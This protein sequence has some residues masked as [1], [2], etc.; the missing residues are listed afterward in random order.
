MQLSSGLQIRSPRPNMSNAMSDA[1]MPMGCLKAMIVT[2][3][4]LITGVSTSMATAAQ[5]Q[6][7]HKL[8]ASPSAA[9]FKFTDHNGREV[10]K[11]TFTNKPS[12]VFFGF[13]HCP[14][15]CPMTLSNL[16]ASLTAL[17]PLA[18]QVNFLFV[19]VDPER[20]TADVLK[21]YLSNFDP[22]IIGLTGSKPSVTKLTESLGVNFNKVDLGGGHYTVDH[23]VMHYML[24]RA[25][26]PAGILYLRSGPAGDARMREKLTVLLGG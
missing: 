3:A 17:G 21:S 11:E 24:D 13:T 1:S 18:D 10:T 6:P 19:T 8:A 26:Q 14:D 15:I 16:T 4:L 25:W 7:L 5:D 12:V 23:P 9:E 22:R 2:V 20:D